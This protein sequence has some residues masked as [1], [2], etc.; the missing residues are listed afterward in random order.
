M[1]RR[2]AAGLVTVGMLSGVS[3]CGSETPAPIV[4]TA[5]NPDATAAR[6]RAHGEWGPMPS[7][8]NAEHIAAVLGTSALAVRSGVLGDVTCQPGLSGKEY[9]QTEGV[10][11]VSPLPATAGLRLSHTC[12][13]VEVVGMVPDQSESSVY[14][15]FGAACPIATSG[16]PGPSASSPHTSAPNSLPP[17]VYGPVAGAA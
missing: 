12:L 11:E 5:P 7:G 4:S 6:C 16:M 10:V 15:E 13:L 9:Q 3:A 1:G 17:S 14:T 8:F 2:L